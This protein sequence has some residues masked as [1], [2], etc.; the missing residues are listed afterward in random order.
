MTARLDAHPA[1]GD[2]ADA[3]PVL[4]RAVSIRDIPRR[5]ACDWRLNS[6]PAVREPWERT[7]T[8]PGCLVHAPEVT[9]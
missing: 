2:A 4:E 1:A 8:Q 5:C 3:T 9:G 7:S 6:R